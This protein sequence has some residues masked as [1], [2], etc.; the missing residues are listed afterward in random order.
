MTD[1]P[2]IDKIVGNCILLRDWIKKEDAKHDAHVKQAKADLEALKGRLQA[3]LDAT[4]QIRGACK[5]GSYYTTTKTSA[6]IADKSEF[7]RFVIGGALFD[8]VDWRA[9]APAVVDFAKENDGKLPPGIKVAQITKVNVRRP[10][11][12]ENDEE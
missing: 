5:T 12:S 6:T 1:Q 9:N 3:F 7:N 11:V 4:G 10:G 8:L 2:D